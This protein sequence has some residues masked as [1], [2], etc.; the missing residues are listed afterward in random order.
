MTKLKAPAGM[1]GGIDVGGQ[2]YRIGD[3]G[4]INVADG[5]DPAQ[6][7]QLGFTR[8]SAAQPAADDAE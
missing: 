6:L 7:L 1:T 5:F 2:H 3:D 4:C 8:V